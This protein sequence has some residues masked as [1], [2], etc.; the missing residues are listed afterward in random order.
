MKYLSILFISIAFISCNAQSPSQTAEVTTEN[1]ETATVTYEVLATSDF[2]AKIASAP[3][4]HLIDV[5][6]PEEFSN[7]AIPNAQ[8]INYYDA[9]FKAQMKALDNS[10]PIFLYCAKGG[11]SGKAS[12]ICKALGFQEIYDLKGGYTDYAAQ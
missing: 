7:G 12:Q 2:V 4:A 10:K 8:N 1:G 11:R 3:D 9:D 5:R 6:T